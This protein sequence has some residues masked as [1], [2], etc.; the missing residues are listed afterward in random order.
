MKIAFLFAGQGSQKTGMGKDFYENRKEFAEIL[1][2]VNLDFDIKELMFQGPEEQLSKTRY[3]QPCMAAFAAGVTAILKKEG[4]TPSYVAGL[5]LGEYSALHAAGVFDAKTLVELVAF[6][7]KAMEDAAQGIECKMSAVMGM[8][9]KALQELCDKVCAQT[10]KY[11][12]VSNFN[13]TGQYVIC[14]EEEAVAVTEG[15]AKEAGAKRCMPLKVSGP[16]HTKFMQPA[17]E[18]LKQKFEEISFGAMQVPVIFNTV[19]DELPDKMTIPEL[20]VQQVQSSIYMEDTLKRLEANG[21]D[22]VVEIGPGKV[23]SGFVKRT[24]PGI[25]SY[26]VEDMESLQTT[27]TALKEN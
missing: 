16:F 13:C 7:G 3:T 10:G 8:E 20:L 26:V 22:T 25:T 23:L 19:A 14:G 11:V 17:G 4:I 9:S 15:L 27:L 6:R 5:S 21:V 18:A 2:G 24:V 12:T 1:N